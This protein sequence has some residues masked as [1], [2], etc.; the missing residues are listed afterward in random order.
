MPATGARGAAGVGAPAGLFVADRGDRAGRQ[1][2]GRGAG[3]GAPLGRAAQGDAGRK[4]GVTTSESKEIK[5]LKA[6]N[7]Q[8]RED[9]EILKTASILFAEELDPRNR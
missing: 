3:V 9:N 8:P 1:A 4:P 5:R 7:R 2:V 6:E